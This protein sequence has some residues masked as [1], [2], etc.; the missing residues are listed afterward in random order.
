MVHVFVL[1]ARNSDE[2]HLKPEQGQCTID[3]GNQQGNI[4]SRFFLLEV[5]GF[6]QSRI[7]PLT[8]SEKCG[9]I[10]ITNNKLVP[11]GSV[12][13]SW[14]HCNSAR[15]FRNM[16]FLVSP[17]PHCDLVIG[18]RSILEHNL[19]GKPNFMINSKKYLLNSKE[20]SMYI[21]VQLLWSAT[22]ANFETIFR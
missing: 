4:V 2:G 8:D 14:Y 13:L 17:H 16:R 20:L 19:L 21:Q 6:P 7:L 12:Y 1:S 9:G 5:L 3:T 18:A 11:Q 22:E 10:G 15:I